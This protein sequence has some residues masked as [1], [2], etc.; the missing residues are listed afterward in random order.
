MLFKRVPFLPL[1]S[2][3]LKRGIVFDAYALDKAVCLAVGLFFLHALDLFGDAC[4]FS[5]AERKH[6]RAALSCMNM[7]EQDLAFKKTVR[8][9]QWYLQR[10]LRLLEDPL[11]L[12]RDLD[13]VLAWLE[14]P[15]S[16]GGW[17]YADSYVQA[18]FPERSRVG[19]PQKEELFSALREYPQILS[20]LDRLYSALYE[21]DRLL[22]AIYRSMQEGQASYVVAKSLSLLLTLEDRESLSTQLKDLGLPESLLLEIVQE[23]NESDPEPSILSYMQEVEKVDRSQLYSAGKILQQA[24]ITFEEKM[25]NVSVWPPERITF[26]TPLG[27]VVIGSTSAD[28]YRKPYALIVEPGGEDVYTEASGS[29]NGLRGQRIAVVVDLDGSDSYV[30]S[31]F[32]GAGVG[33]MGCGVVLDSRGDDVYRAS[34]LGQ[35]SGLAGLGWLIDRDGNDTYRAYALSQGSGVI[36][37]GVLE[38]SQ[39]NDRYDVGIYGQA[40]A[41]ILGYGLL[42][43]S[44]GSDA[45]SS[46]GAEPDYERHDHRF[47]SLSQGF[48]I[49]LRPFVGGG[50]ALLIDTQGN[51]TYTCDV[52][53]QGTSYWYG[54]GMLIDGSGDDHYKAY[55]Y[56]QG[57]GIHLS[58]GLLYDGSGDDTYVGEILCQGNA[59]DY[60][61]GMLFDKRGSDTYVADHHSQGRGMNNG[62]ALLMDGSGNDIYMA[63]QP[64][65]CQGIG[66]DGGYREYG[67]IGLLLDLSGRDSY[68]CGASD[69]ARLLRPDYGVLYDLLD[70]ET[71]ED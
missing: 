8:V 11:A 44:D 19:T 42:W 22:A 6:L 53:G 39:G 49:G 34:F 20:S 23:E 5:A 52:F 9:P 56:G 29:A 27:T 71:R 33:L 7:T 18:V 37:L 62:L 3:C 46:G 21:V 69:G 35:G 26:N 16:R 12:T 55:H 58:T 66:N 30:S 28:R 14:A 31:G 64:D 13:E 43:D 1:V 50:I 47:L 68:S 24:L 10:N 17:P 45:Y 60:A 67:S 38:D 70:E 59:H 48:S 57:S 15:P 61:V 41:G 25:K 40:F 54:L 4:F 63:R 65:L 36:G 51:D 2:L 32:L